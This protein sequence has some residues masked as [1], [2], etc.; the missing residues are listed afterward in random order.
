[1]FFQSKLNRAMEWLKNKNKSS[2]SDEIHDENEEDLKL[3]K[4]DI[5]ALIISAVLVFS[6]IIIILMII[7]YFVLQIG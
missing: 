1:M 6:P 7:L 2:S 5:L 4:T 3:E